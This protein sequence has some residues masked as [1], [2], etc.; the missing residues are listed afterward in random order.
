MDP[1]SAMMLVGGAIKLIGGVTT[2]FGN[3]GT[4]IRNEGDLLR[5]QG[6]RSAQ[7]RGQLALQT[8]RAQTQ[9][10]DATTDITRQQS[11]LGG[12]LTAGAA[13]SG[14]RSS[15]GSVQ[16]MVGDVAGQAD[17]QRDRIGEQL[18]FQMRGIDLDRV[19]GE[20]DI[21]KLGIAADR[22]RSDRPLRFIGDLLGA[23]AG[24]V[25]SATQILRYQQGRQ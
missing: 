24:G 10:R 6:E 5:E 1:I 25:D 18:Q 3:R 20:Y 7:L 9:A 16:A 23:G 17:L 19:R 4:S 8:D 2:A 12:Q 21:E 13:A 22:E 14:V 11:I 15:S